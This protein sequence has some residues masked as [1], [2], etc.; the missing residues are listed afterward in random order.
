MTESVQD[1]RVPLH[2]SHTIEMIW[3][4][5]ILYMEGMENY[6]KLITTSSC[7]YVITSSI[8]QMFREF[9][10]YGFIQTHKSYLV[11]KEHIQRYHKIGEIELSHGY[12]IPVARR[13]REGVC[14]F[15]NT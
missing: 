2:S 13:R 11:N 3:I 14:S 8:G 6:T 1:I 10:K 15:L 9:E 12:K 4:R 5:N 7:R